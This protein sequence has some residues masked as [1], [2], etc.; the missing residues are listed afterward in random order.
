MKRMR[1]IGLLIA[2]ICLL[3]LAREAF[4]ADQVVTDCGDNGGANQLR[5]KIDAAQ[6]SGGGVITFTCGPATILLNG[7]LPFI[8]TTVTINGAGGITLSGGNGSRILFVSTGGDLY[9][10][11]LTLTNGAIGNPGGAIR[12][13]S[14]NLYADNVTIKK[15]ASTD[16]GGGLHAEFAFVSLTNVTFQENHA[17]TYGGGAYYSYS[18]VVL[19]NVNFLTNTAANAGGALVNDKGQVTWTGGSIVGNSAV[20]TGGMYTVNSD[21][22]VNHYSH[23]RQVVISENKAASGYGGGLHVALDANLTLENSTVHSN[24]AKHGAGLLNYGTAA[25]TNVTLSNNNATRYGGGILNEDGQMSLTNVTLAYNSAPDGGGILHYSGTSKKIILLNTIVAKSPSGG[26][27][28]NASGA[29]SLITS[30]GF[31]LSDDSSCAP[32]LNQIGDKNGAQYDPLLGALADNGGP[33]FTHLPQTGS[34]VIDGGTN[35][36]CPATDQRG[37]TRVGQG[38]ACDIGAVEVQ[39]ACASKPDQPALL[40]PGNNKKPKARKSRLIGTIQTV[41]TLTMSLSITVPPRGPKRSRKRI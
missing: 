26:N 33:T 5:A 24:S 39:V 10:N 19:E 14:G 17:G 2:G 18:E 30:S 6:A 27:C 1:L 29:G 35:S 16:D 15:S 11:N 9:L 41:W 37:F 34:P 23:L 8:S 3:M 31:N 21:G 38:A 22:D 36:G 20:D 40:S 32:Y 28:Y 12:V 4:A 25:L 7:Q 13:S